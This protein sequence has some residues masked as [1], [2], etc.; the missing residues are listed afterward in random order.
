MKLQRQPSVGPTSEDTITKLADLFRI[1]GDPTRLRIVLSCLAEPVHVS[2]IAERLRLSP[3]LVS[4][5]LRLLRA[6]RILSGERR[7][8][9]IF[10]SATDEHIRCVI[11]DM[12]A[13]V[14]EL[15][16]FKVSD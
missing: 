10:Y 6:T 12:V 16:D 5:H 7:G 8:K 15:R 13:H 3:S 1:M 2:E 4:H 11:C 9:K 14:D